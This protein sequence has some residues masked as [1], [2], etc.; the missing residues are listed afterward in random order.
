MVL[1]ALVALCI[2]FFRID[3]RKKVINEVTIRQQND[4]LRRH[5][6]EFES[7]L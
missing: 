6:Q 5:L 2:L 7:V 4:S 3:D 1:I